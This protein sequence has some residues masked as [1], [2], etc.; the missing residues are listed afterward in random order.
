MY[1]LIVFL[2]QSF[3]I[4]QHLFSTHCRLDLMKIRENKPHW[5]KKNSAHVNPRGITPS[6][7][8]RASEQCRA[9]HCVRPAY[10]FP[11]QNFELNQ[12]KGSVVI[13]RH[14]GPD[15]QVG[16][17]PT[18]PEG[19]EGGPPYVTRADVGLVPLLSVSWI[20]PHSQGVQ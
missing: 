4:F 8:R 13:V 1:L 14:L 20:R 16:P 18:S 11:D 3:L 19:A 7:S 6:P 2:L 15:P 10:T 5:Q 17:L 12:Q 9:T